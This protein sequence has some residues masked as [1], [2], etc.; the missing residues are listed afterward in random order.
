MRRRQ[1][2]R[3]FCQH[4]LCTS[5]T[6]AFKCSITA[7]LLGFFLLLLRKGREFEPLG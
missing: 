1:P 4:S 2:D 7:T 3:R 6:D 5:D